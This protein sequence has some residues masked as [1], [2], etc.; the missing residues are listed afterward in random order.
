MKRTFSVL[1]HFPVSFMD[2]E[3]IKERNI[4]CMLLSFYMGKFKVVPH[5]LL[6]NLPGEKYEE[7]LILCKVC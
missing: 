4:L 5:M 2:F 6:P 7:V 3:I 1:T